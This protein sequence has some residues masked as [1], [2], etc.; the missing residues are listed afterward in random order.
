M[1]RLL[2]KG[3]ELLRVKL[4]RRG[5]MLAVGAVATVL[6]EMAAAP[7]PATLTIS[8]VKAATLLAAEEIVVGGCVSGQVLALMEEAVRGMVWAKAKLIVAL[9]TIGLAVGGAGW[10]GYEGLAAT[11]QSGSEVRAQAP[12]AKKPGEVLAEEENNDGK[13][14]SGD[15]LPPS[16]IARLGT[17]RFRQEGFVDNLI[18][19]PGGK[20]LIS[21]AGSLAISWDA[22][23]GKELYRISGI[24]KDRY[25]SPIDISPDGSTLVYLTN[26][27]RSGKPELVFADLHNG[28]TLRTLDT[29][30]KWPLKEAR[31]SHRL[32]RF[33]LRYLPDGK[34]LAIADLEGKVHIL[35]ADTGKL[36]AKVEETP[37]PAK[38][39]QIDERKS[40]DGEFPGMVINLHGLALSP[41]AKT[42]ALGF[43][44]GLLLIDTSTGKKIR[45]IDPHARG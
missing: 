20:T 27:H 36:L 25:V 33:F 21:R 44:N 19:A 15:P 40:P 39:T 17:L 22:R 4:E 35:D 10:A 37:L 26:E 42:M 18:Y 45:Q 11:G 24:T 34:R 30:G 38:K 5:I 8:T 23:T 7:L 1:A 3:R 43:S 32:F 31:E 12:V 16:A 14:Q 28:K 41:N 6:T 9:A 2:A 13:D 29:P